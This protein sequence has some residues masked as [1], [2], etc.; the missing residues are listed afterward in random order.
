[1]FL[2]RELA[3]LHKAKASRASEAEEA[4]LSRDAQAKEKL[5]MALEKAQ[6]EAQI[7]QEA[8]ADQVRPLH[9]QHTDHAGKINSF[10]YLNHPD[11]AFVLSCLGGWPE[12]GSAEGRATAG[13]KGRLFSGR[14]QWATAGNIVRMF[15]IKQ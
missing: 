2:I 3:D 6:G 4:A 8:L 14:D 13:K 11:W 12:I 1:M 9:W 7:Q 10:D 15:K 5:S